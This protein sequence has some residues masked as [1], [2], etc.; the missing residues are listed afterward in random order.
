MSHKKPERHSVRFELAP[1]NEAHERLYAYLNELAE[2][3]EA[4]E[5]MRRTLIAA[6]PEA[7][8]NRVSTVDKRIEQG[9]QAAPLETPKVEQPKPEPPQE[10][11]PVAPSNGYKTPAQLLAERKAAAA[12][13]HSQATF[14]GGKP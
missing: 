8:I 9:P 13:K 14:G 5:W 3:N 1:E 12:A 10:A 4:A 2:T 7:F 6:I 11:Q